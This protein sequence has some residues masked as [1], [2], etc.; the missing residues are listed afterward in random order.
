[1]QACS[2]WAPML[3]WL[4]KAYSHSLLVVLR[5]FPQK[6]IGHADLFWRICHEVC[7]CK[8]RSL[9]A[10][11]TI[12][13]DCDQLIRKAQLAEIRKIVA[14]VWLVL[15]NFQKCVCMCVSVVSAA[16]LIAAEFSRYYDEFVGYR[17]TVH[18]CSAA[19]VRPSANDASP[20]AD[21]SLNSSATAW[22]SVGRM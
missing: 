16:L 6:S 8:I 5:D 15:Q 13:A 20:H 7:A 14:L 9:C 4:E 1:M 17:V 10:A 12:C 21:R 19:A 22:Y 2:L 3:S 11:D 18:H